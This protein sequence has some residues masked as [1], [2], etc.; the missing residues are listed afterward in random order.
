MARNG[1]THDDE[2][3]NNYD[4]V[5]AGDTFTDT[6]KNI[7]KTVDFVTTDGV[8]TVI[9][10]DGSGVMI[11]SFNDMRESGRLVKAAADTGDDDATI[12]TDGGVDVPDV[13]DTF[14]NCAGAVF[15]AAD[16]T[17]D[18]VV[19]SDG[20]ASTFTEFQSRT[21]AGYI[22]PAADTHTDTLRR[23]IDAFDD[24]ADFDPVAWAFDRAA[25]DDDTVSIRMTA[26]RDGGVTFDIDAAPAYRDVFNPDHILAEHF[27][28]IDAFPA[29][30]DT[31]RDRLDLRGVSNGRVG[32]VI[33]DKDTGDID[34][35]K[36]YDGDDA[37]EAAV[38]TALRHARDRDDGD[39][40]DDDTDAGGDT[41]T[42]ADTTIN[43]TADTSGTT[44][45]RGDT[46]SST[47]HDHA[48]DV[49][50][51]DIDKCR[52][53]GRYAPHG[54]D[55]AADCRH[56]EPMTD[57]DT[58]TVT[59]GGTPADS[60]PAD[61]YEF[62]EVHTDIGIKGGA[63]IEF[64]PK[65]HDHPEESDFKNIGESD[66]LTLIR[67]L[68]DAF[69]FTA[70]H[71]ADTDDNDGLSNAVE[72]TKRRTTTALVVEAFP[73]SA[74]PN[75]PIGVCAAIG[76]F[77]DGSPE[78]AKAALETA[79]NSIDTD[80]P[81]M[82][83]GGHPPDHHNEQ[84]PTASAGTHDADSD[85]DGGASVMNDDGFVAPFCPS[86]DGDDPFVEHEESLHG[87]GDGDRV[88][89]TYRTD[90]AGNHLT[91]DATVVDVQHAPGSPASI[92]AITVKTDDGVTYAIGD[93]GKVETIDNYSLNGGG[94]EVRR[95]RGT[96]VDIEVVD[97]IGDSDDGDG[98]DD[99]DTDD[100]D[101]DDDTS[102][103]GG[104]QWLG[105]Q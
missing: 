41:D 46:R 67:E 81:T 27:D 2:Q 60:E 102:T 95:D 28:M 90:K 17:D 9:F 51:T 10:E 62:I 22:V 30:F 29:A 54:F 33:V 59:D 99:T 43:D 57:N 5:T 6:L 7:E 58:P 93:D 85:D 88:S 71:D 70:T 72:D 13:G 55:H 8:T 31:M 19:W 77:K 80:T 44:T 4:D 20:T 47:P 105:D 94:N 69:S 18:T 75:V 82:T 36:L 40:G 89:F 61:E 100:G 104:F 79:A 74:P 21:D 34:R 84:Q 52:V 86:S 15:T 91:R 78:T 45:T 97:R 103:D 64:R 76:A 16:V 23:Y 37:D 53:C 96:L 92:W 65:G 98:D 14:V 24:V 83:D 87:D 50:P 56:F 49:S 73:T 48:S 38:A 11:D 1:A 42:D 66:A 12:M 101:G 3:S 39:D 25:N 32:E 35:V 26:D 63:N 68:I